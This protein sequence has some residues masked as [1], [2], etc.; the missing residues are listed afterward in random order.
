VEVV[1]VV[2]ASVV[3]LVALV[4][5]VVALV[6]LVAS[7]VAV[8]VEHWYSLFTLLMSNCVKPSLL[9]RG[10]VPSSA[11]IVLRTPRLVEKAYSP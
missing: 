8:V 9:P 10:L 3:A 7:V 6:A 1:D 11:S 5:S 4:A 2:V